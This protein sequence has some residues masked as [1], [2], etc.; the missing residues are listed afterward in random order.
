[1]SKI[2]KTIIFFSIISIIFILGKHILPTNNY[3]FDFHDETQPARIHQFVLN[4]K[5]FQIPPRIAPQFS[6]NL[7]Y[8]VFNYYAPTAY[9]ITSFFHL[10]GF[11]IIDA[12]K[13]SFILALIV[14]FISMYLLSSSFFGFYQSIMASFLYVSSPWMAVEIF[15]RGNLA[16]VWFLAFLPLAFWV[17]YKNSI[18]VSINRFF[19]LTIII[20]GA[21][22]SVHN[23]LSFVLL[24]LLIVFILIQKNKAKNFFAL[25]L[26]LLLNAYFFIPAILE[27]NQTH[28]LLIAKNANYSSHL[29]CLWQLWTTPFWG[30]GG[31][32]PGCIDGMSFMIGKPQIILGGIG[33]LFM[34]YLIIKK[35]KNSL[36]YIYFIILTLISVYLSTDLSY[37]ISSSFFNPY[38]SFF[39]FPWRFLAFAVFG[40]SLL[41]ASLIMPKKVKKAE[42]ILLVISLIIVSYNAKFFTKYKLPN[43]IFNNEFLEEKYIL[44]K[45]AY[46]I[47]EYLPKTVDYQTWLKHEP[48]KDREYLIDNKLNNQ[49]F[50][51]YLNQ[52]KPKIIA[53]DY[54]YKKSKIEQGGDIIINISYLPYWRIF[55]DQQ[56]IFPQKFDPLGRPI[57]K[58][59]GQ[60]TLTVKYEQTLIQKTANMVTFVTIFYLF[61]LN[62]KLLNQRRIKF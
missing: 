35:K 5:N 39:Q 28:V 14:A 40:M 48:K 49:S 47:A 23:I 37:P 27:I 54:F 6:F 59:K 25:I 51:Y 15:V 12:L 36:T 43:E 10:V 18:F 24:P 57:I 56:E 29:L 30:Y 8:P 2:K 13:I 41:A 58:V 38:L 60:S 45:V 16:T 1:M 26:A 53:N 4:L 9:W 21:S 34:V 61:L 19:I 31:S 62:K 52:K 7:G 17:L 55:I 46:K 42:I 11:S 3:F 44:N 22:L 20:L 32:N 50:V 33:L